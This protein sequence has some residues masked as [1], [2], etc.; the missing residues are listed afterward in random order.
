[1]AAAVK[2]ETSPLITGWGHSCG[3]A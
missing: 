1:M 3:N 2:N